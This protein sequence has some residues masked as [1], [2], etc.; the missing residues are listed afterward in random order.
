MDMDKFIKETALKAEDFLNSAASK[1][2][3]ETNIT[4][5]ALNA[6]FAL[7]KYF[8]LMDI[9]KTYDIDLYISVAKSTREAK[10]KLVSIVNKLYD[11]GGIKNG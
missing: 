9:I 7:G 2:E 5:A 3:R 10:E 6:E 8:A 4:T 11:N 1:C